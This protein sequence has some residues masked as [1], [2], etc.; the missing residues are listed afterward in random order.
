[1]PLFFA[2]NVSENDLNTSKECLFESKQKNR[3]K[4]KVEKNFFSL[5]KHP[6][7]VRLPFPLQ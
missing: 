2:I 7:I 3:K 1:M 5:K 6:I 4:K